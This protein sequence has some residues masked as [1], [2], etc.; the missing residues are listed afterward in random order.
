[1][2][3]R[4]VSRASARSNRLKT[5]LR[6]GSLAVAAGLLAA[7]ALAKEDKA[8]RKAKKETAHKKGSEAGS[9]MAVKL[10]PNSPMALKVAPAKRS[11]DDDRVLGKPRGPSPIRG[12]R[13]P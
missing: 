5:A 11:P 9:A 1:M 6:V 4:H 2:T 10:A 7:P 8:E 13:T 3:D 12:N